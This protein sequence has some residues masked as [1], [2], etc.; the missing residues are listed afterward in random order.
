MLVF[1][2]G[3]VLTCTLAYVGGADLPIE[4]TL[5]QALET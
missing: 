4:P 5:G 1:A 2:M 3:C